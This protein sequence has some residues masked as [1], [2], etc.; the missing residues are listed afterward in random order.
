MLKSNLHKRIV[1]LL[2]ALQCVAPVAQGMV[3]RV[4]GARSHVIQPAKNNN[5]QQ[6]FYADLL[7]LLVPV[8]NAEDQ[9]KKLVPAV[10]VG[11]PEPAAPEEPILDL[12][13]TPL[14]AS[15]QLRMYLQVLQKLSPE[16]QNKKRIVDLKSIEK[17]YFATGTES[18]PT[19]TVLKQLGITTPMGIVAAC[20]RATALPS[21]ADIQKRQKLVHF[22]SQRP[23]LLCQLHEAYS[24]ISQGMGLF[25]LFF[26]PLDAL[27][28][29]TF[30][31][32]GYGSSMLAL[33]LLQGVRGFGIFSLL[34]P[35]LSYLSL[36]SNFGSSY[37]EAKKGFQEK[38]L[39]LALLKALGIAGAFPFKFLTGVV[40]QEALRHYP[41]TYVYSRDPY[42]GDISRNEERASVGSSIGDTVLALEK[43]TKMMPPSF[44]QSL[45]SNKIAQYSLAYLIPVMLDL[46]WTMNASQALSSVRYEEQTDKHMH[47]KLAGLQQIAEGLRKID[48][49]AR[50]VRLIEL[51]QMLISLRTFL[52]QP[53]ES[54]AGI[55]LKE[56]QSTVFAPEW[57]NKLANKAA[58]LAQGPRIMRAFSIANEQ[59]GVIVQLLQKAGELE[60]ILAAA[61]ALARGRDNKER[62]VCLVTIDTDEAPRMELKNFWNILV[63]GPNVCNSI[64]LG[65]TKQRNA[66]ISGPNGC[67]KSTIE[68][69]LALQVL[70]FTMAGISTSE[71]A[72]MSLF[73]SLRLYRDDNKED[74]SLRQSSFMVEGGFFR[75][76]CSDIAALNQNEKGFALIDEALGSTKQDLG[77]DLFCSGIKEKLVPQKQNITVIAAHMPEVTALANVLPNDIANYHVELIEH[78]TNPQV[79]NEQWERTYLLKEGVDVSWFKDPAKSKRWVTWLMDHGDMLQSER[80]VEVQAA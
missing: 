44:M 48:Q 58:L 73:T 69:A 13:V 59:K 5:Q 28:K 50:E 51:D 17:V 40:S 66:V 2:L 38:S 68:T 61:D 77:V 3:P 26:K 56:L 14:S 64:S 52:E 71:Q 75:K 19:H 33:R 47:T 30:E 36:Y 46:Q 70:L 79:G 32:F 39:P 6:T 53:A 78:E 4:L 15:E 16:T 63:T 74:P 60:V 37:Q 49:V 57:E 35:P 29:N 1:W 43:E 45:L 9:K 10:D 31:Q 24:Q 34:V 80:Q 8:S 11:A 76:F 41:G 72:H 7:E 12:T 65:G 62:P 20:D 27:L 21:L 67:G 25:M 42:S 18:D 22:L 55:L 23:D 54:S